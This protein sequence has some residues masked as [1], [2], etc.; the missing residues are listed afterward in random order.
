MGF[1][2]YND[3]ILINED[4]IISIEKCTK[5][6]GCDTKYGLIFTLNCGEPLIKYVYFSCESARDIEFE[7]LWEEL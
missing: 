6:V 7:N 3:N 5:G 2:R 1:I 4:S